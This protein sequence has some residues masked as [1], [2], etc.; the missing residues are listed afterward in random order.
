M[1]ELVL[2]SA[3]V[4]AP[5]RL[6][7]QQLMRQYATPLGFLLRRLGVAS[8]DVDDVLQRVWLTVARCLANVRAGSER[9]FL[10]TVARRE[11]GHE[12]RSYRRRCEVACS[13][14]DELSAPALAAEEGLHRQQRLAQACALLQQLDVSL[15]VVL[16]LCELEDASSR[17]VACWLQIPVG[18][19]KSRLRRARA[20][21]A[22]LAP[23]SSGSAIQLTRAAFASSAAS[24]PASPVAPRTATPCQAAATRS[25]AE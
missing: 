2:A 1:N 4:P 6:P 25:D 14:L 10:W 12:L 11:A 21:C 16:L 8:C 19:A 13:T 5:T 9:A 20:A 17:E 23:G 22:Q 24:S 18:T 7:L 3:R 15:R